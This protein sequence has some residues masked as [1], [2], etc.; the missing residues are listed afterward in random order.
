MRNITLNNGKNVIVNENSLSDM[1]E[2]VRTELSPELA[3][4]F[5]EMISDRLFDLEGEREA[6]TQEMHSYES[7]L[8]DAGRALHDVL[9]N[10]EELLTYIVENKRIRKEH[11]TEVLLE[12]RLLAM[13]NL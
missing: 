7:D 9:E 8:E 3:D 4:A 5:E 6:L 12:I 11:L 2:T 10:T 13:E 1:M